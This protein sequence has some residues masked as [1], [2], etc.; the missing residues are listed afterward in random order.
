MNNLFKKRLSRTDIFA[1]S[2]QS[3]LN[4][5]KEQI[6][7][8]RIQPLNNISKTS[9]RFRDVF[10]LSNLAKCFEIKSTIY[11]LD[12]KAV[13]IIESL[14]ESHFPPQQFILKIKRS[15]DSKVDNIYN[16]YNLNI[17]NYQ[18]SPN[19]YTPNGYTPNGYTPNGYNISSNST[20][21]LDILQKNHHP[22]IVKIYNY[23]VI[24]SYSYCITELIDGTNLYEYIKHT[25]NNITDAMIVNIL[26]QLVNGLEH[27]HQLNI[28]HCDLKPD[29]IMIDKNLNIKI[30]DFDLSILTDNMNGFISDKIFGTLEYIAPESYDL[31]IYSKKSDIW[32]LGVILYVLILNEFPCNKEL[33]L[34]NSHSNICRRNV[35]K[36]INFKKVKEYMQ[37]NNRSILLYDL[38]IK[39][40]QFNDKNRPDLDEIKDILN[41]FI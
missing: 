9:T 4:V 18:N 35:F 10:C 30:I 40:L 32:Q 37:N 13:F 6:P 20:Q 25:S 19:G 29:N 16:T 1:K 27:L 17:L 24:D 28:I 2:Q 31:N 11:E 36:N 21:I 22:T 34:I 5:I 39:L 38:L 41:S 33:S 23:G 15:I 12:S 3:Q 14:L 26:Q 8:H 7:P